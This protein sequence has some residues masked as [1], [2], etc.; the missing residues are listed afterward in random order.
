MRKNTPERRYE[1][2]QRERTEIVTPNGVRISHSWEKKEKW[3]LYGSI[4]AMSLLAGL[5]LIARRWG[6]AVVGRRFAC[7][8]FCANLP[9]LRRAS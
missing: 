9:R 2:E 1:V 8:N 3:V 6:N 5:A 4:V 7:A